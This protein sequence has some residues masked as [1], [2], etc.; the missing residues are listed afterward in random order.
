MDTYYH[1]KQALIE[2]GI[3][4]DIIGCIMEYVSDDKKKWARNHFKICMVLIR[5]YEWRKAIWGSLRNTVNSMF[6]FH[7]INGIIICISHDTIVC[8]S[9]VK[10][11]KKSSAS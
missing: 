3:N 6:Q 4:P 10:Q 8:I 11:F 1:K 2:A 9:H 5:E 7:H